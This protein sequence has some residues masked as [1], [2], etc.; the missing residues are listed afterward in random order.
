[1]N[2]AAQ[3]G[4]LLAA[5]PD[6]RDPNFFRSVV[7]VFQHDREGAA[8][9]VLN[10]QLPATLQEVAREVLELEGEFPE[11][12]YWGG[13]VEGPLMAL[14][15]SVALAEHQVIPGLF[16]SLQKQNLQSLLERRDHP[17]RIF[18]GYAGW[19][20][21]QLERELEAGGWLTLPAAVEQA[22]AQPELLWQQVCEA[23][24]RGIISPR[25]R[26]GPEPPTPEWN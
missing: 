11:S 24:G 12:M 19:G 14:H 1:M 18:T 20:P 15:Q 21:G 16:F 17:F 3:T 10:R 9:L 25:G 13:P 22:F 4:N 7:L 8:G 2:T 6:L 5:V 23:I 26:I